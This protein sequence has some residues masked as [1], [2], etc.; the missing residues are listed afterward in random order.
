MNA[1][2]EATVGT[3]E[4]KAI[5]RA[6]VWG[7]PAWFIFY[8]LAPLLMAIP[9]GWYGAGLGSEFGRGGSLALWMVICCLSW[10]FSDVFSRALAAL[11][12]SAHFSPWALLTGGYLLNMALSSLYNPAV[13]EL[14]LR[15]GLATPTPMVEAYFALERNLLDPGYAW[16][17][18]VA[19]IPGLLFWLAGN[20]AFQ[21]MTGVP[22]VSRPEPAE[23]ATH[24]AAAEPAG[25]SESP[26]A[27]AAPDKPAADAAAVV[28]P[29]FFERLTRLAGLTVEEL[30]AVEAED[31]YIQVH[32]TRGK[33]LVYYRFRDA[34]AE[35][36]GV[37]GLQIHRSA[38]VSRPGITEL[39]ERG[40]NL[41]VVLVTGERL[42]V[43]LSNRGALLQ[44]GLKVR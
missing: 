30:V 8:V 27:A 11:L 42:R 9:L 28:P 20:Y 33:E 38:W 25:P 2:I 1:R 18:F 32:S 21:R 14:L 43:S 22:R 15:T 29:R 26:G 13:V 37:P 24:T 17:L 19:G 40:R 12:R 7:S 44:A 23:R 16:L 4:D 35:L 41:H 34:L 3:Q 36:D 6:P 31:H 10:W 5:P 39:D